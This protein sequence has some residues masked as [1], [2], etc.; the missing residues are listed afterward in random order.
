MKNRKKKSIF[1]NVLSYLIFIILISISWILTEPSK[2]SETILKKN[3][4]IN[5]KVE[6]KEK[7]EKKIKPKEIKANV[8][9]K[10]KIN[11]KVKK[12][13][14]KTQKKNIKNTTEITIKKSSIKRHILKGKN[15]ILSGGHFPKV[16]AEYKSSI[17]FTN[18]MTY[19]L[20]HLKSKFYIYNLN[21]GKLIKSINPLTDKISNPDVFDLSDFSKSIRVLSGENALEQLKEKVAKLE[22]INNFDL[23]PILVIKNDIEYLITSAIMSNNGS[24]KYKSY[25]GKYKIRNN[26][27]YLELDEAITEENKR[28]DFNLR[29]PLHY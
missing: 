29:I 15:M 12:V 9:F 2:Q 5:K 16:Q 10:E 25:F 13:V 27:L 3:Y 21:S 4:E 18:Y 17:G 11:H 1:S 14:K 6:K 19:H 22:Y 7:K 26:T 23:V 8:V 24:N 20:N 28:V